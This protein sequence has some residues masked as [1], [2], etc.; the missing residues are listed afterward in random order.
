MGEAVSYAVGSSVSFNS[1]WV[2]AFS[3]TSYCTMTLDTNLDYRVYSL[4]LT[5]GLSTTSI[6]N[7]FTI[8]FVSTTPGE[9]TW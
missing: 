8:N 7:G 2:S 1:N 9:A 3:V 6:Y 4:Y 5:G